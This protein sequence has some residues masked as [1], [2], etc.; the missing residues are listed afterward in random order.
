MRTRITGLR[1]ARAL[2]AA[3][4]LAGPLAACEDLLDIDPPSRVPAEGIETPG[5]AQLLV[6]SA[7]G[8]FECALGSY[9]VMG[10]LIGEELEDALQTA[11][12]FPYDR[13]RFTS[14]DRR[15]A[16][17]DC[18]ALG[19]YM[20]LQRARASADNAARLLEGWTDAEVRDRTALLATAYAYAGYALVLLGE[21]FCEGTISSLDA[22]GS[23]VYGTLMTR[24]QLQAAAEE[25]FTKALAQPGISD[26]VRYL[27]LLG[28]AR[29]RLNRGQYAA[30]RAD[31]AL[32]PASWEGIA[33]T[34]GNEETRRQNRVWA[35]VDSLG[36]NNSTSIGEPYRALNDPRVS[37]K[38]K[39]RA[40]PVGRPLWGQRKYTRA[41]SPLPI[42]RYAEAQLI[43]AE[44]D[45]RA[46][47]TAE[48]ES[49][50]QILN[51]YRARGNQADIAPGATQAEL[52]AALVDQR[53]REFFLEGRHLGDAIRFGLALQ[54]AADT[55]YFNGGT[56]GT[57]LCLPL[58]DVERDNNPNID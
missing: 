39:N 10:A 38:N 51:I 33:A 8:D 30:A 58:P 3:A 34:A 26:N 53:R 35:Q 45:I 7:V 6:N 1:A 20:P 14:S 17:N 25:R 57:S 43:I 12:R 27:A 49:A 52:L 22:A 29:S 40:S 15:Y 32:V 19:V 24:D 23:P 42:T 44:A 16:V 37:V 46:G 2:L 13:R 50:R 41:E 11:D 47:G 56:Y 48:L 4:L 28:R 55:P 9:I 31:A 5:N 21:G 18:D 36:N 54:P